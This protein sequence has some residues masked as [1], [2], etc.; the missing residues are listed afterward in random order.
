VVTRFEWCIDVSRSDSRANRSRKLAR[1]ASGDPISFK[2][3][4]RSRLS[5]VA[6]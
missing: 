4:V 6:R 2:A 5:C 3:T 1:L